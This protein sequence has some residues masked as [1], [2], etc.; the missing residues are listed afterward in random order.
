MAVRVRVRVEKTKQAGRD[1]KSERTRRD[2]TL[3]R[4]SSRLV[5]SQ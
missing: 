5:S 2:A 1:A 4:I 3:T